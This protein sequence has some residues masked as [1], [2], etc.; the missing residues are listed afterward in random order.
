MKKSIY[1]FAIFSLVVLVLSSCKKD[2]K[3]DGII[4]GVI[5]DVHF[6]IE[7]NNADGINLLQNDSYFQ[8]SYMKG[9]VA[10]SVQRPNLDFPNGYAIVSQRN[11]G[12]DGSDE[13]CVKVFS[14]DYYDNSNTSVTYVKFGNNTT[15]TFKCQFYRAPNLVHLIKI[16]LNGTLVWDAQTAESAPFI[17]ITK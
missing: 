2:T 14:S 1:S 15:D 7:Y 9:G 12:P 17:H 10:E 3:D 5:I 11:T 13:L 4:K 8:V 16:W 6:F